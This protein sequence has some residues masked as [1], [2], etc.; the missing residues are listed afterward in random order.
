MNQN[1]NHTFHIPVMGLGYTVDTPLKVA[2]FGISSVVSIMHD[3]LLEQLREFYCQKIG[4][5]F[6]AAPDDENRRAYRI[7]AYLDLMQ[8]MVDD[9]MADLVQQRFEIGQEIVRYF[10]LLPHDSPLSREYQHMLTLSGEAKEEAQNKLRQAIF[11]GDIDVNIMTKVDNINFSKSG[12]PLPG[13]YSDASAALRGF[14]LSKVKSSVIFSAGLNPRLFAYLEEFDDFFPD[15]K[16]QISKKIVLK[17]SDLRSAIIQGKYLAK[18]GLWVNEFRIESGLNCGGHAFPGDGYLL[19]PILEEFKNQRQNLR[20]ELF[21]MCNQALTRK[22]KPLLAPDQTLRVTAQ[23]GIGT[24][25]EDAFLREYYQLDGTG[26]GSPF[27]LVPDVT[28][29]DEGTLQKLAVAKPEDYFL[30][31]ASP[32]GIPFNNFRNST[33]ENQRMERIEKGRPGSPCYL[34]HLSFNTEF[35]DKPIC[36]SSRQYQDKKIKALKAEGLSPDQLEAAIAEVV[37][38]DCLCEGLAVSVL[39]RNGIADLHNLDAVAIC[40]G[41]NLAYFSGVFSLDEM[42]DHI[43]G[44]RNLLNS[45]NRP[46]MFIK[47]LDMYIQYLLKEISKHLDTLNEKKKGYF[48]TFK[49]NILDGIEYYHQLASKMNRESEEAIGEFRRML[50]QLKANIEPAKFYVAVVE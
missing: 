11:P 14:A 25:Q 39:Q 35:T 30:S 40:P 6:T 2:R 45:L 32:L 26:W 41:P 49:K 18:K 24:Y 13:M 12:E 37:V 43:Y 8:K 22:N 21:A 1:Y 20:D 46:N 48:E 38:K 42:V 44:R 47:E 7:Q 50:E 23:G 16:G 29:V 27:L 15:D 28:N 5:P 3:T 19:G 17:V 36:A 34:K 33:S 9:Q 4:I 31:D 10:E